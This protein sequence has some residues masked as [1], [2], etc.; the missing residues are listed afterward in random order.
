MVIYL[1]YTFQIIWID[2]MLVQHL[3]VE[4]PSAAEFG[5]ACKA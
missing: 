4:H 3:L 5:K 2:I 1:F